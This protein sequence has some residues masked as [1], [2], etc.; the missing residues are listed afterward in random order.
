MC[1]STPLICSNP[2]IDILRQ[3]WPVQSPVVALGDRHTAS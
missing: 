3:P 1:W 2:T